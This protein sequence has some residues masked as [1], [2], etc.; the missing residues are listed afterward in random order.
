MTR[1]IGLGLRGHGG[2]GLWGVGWLLVALAGVTGCGREKPVE[3]VMV[4][5]GGTNWTLDQVTAVALAWDKGWLAPERTAQNYDRELSRFWDRTRNSKDPWEELLGYLP[6]V[7]GLPKTGVVRRSGSYEVGELLPGDEELERASLRS[8]MS[9]WREKGWKLVQSEWRTVGFSMK[10]TQPASEVRMTLH[11]EL[12]GAGRRMTVQGELLVEW[13]H[14]GNGSGSGVVPGRVRWLRGEWMAS[15][16]RPRFQEVYRTELEP[17]VS[18]RFAGPVLFA[19]LK[20]AGRDE[21]LLAGANRILGWEVDR[22]WKLRPLL[23]VE[24]L[25]MGSTVMDADRD[26]RLD[27]VSASSAAILTFRGDGEGGFLVPPMVTGAE[28]VVEPMVVAQV[29][30]DRDGL[31][32]IWV[33]QYLSPGEAP[34]P[35]DDADDGYPSSFWRNDGGT[36]TRKTDESGLGWKGRR[37]VLSGVFLDLDGDGWSDLVR[38]CDYA[39]LDVLR[40]GRDGRFEPVT[41][42]WFREGR[43][44]GMS[45]GIADLDGDGRPDLVMTGMTSPTA[46]RMKKLGIEHPDFPGMRRRREEMTYGN[47][48][49][50]NRGNGRWEVPGWGL[51]MADTGWTWGCAWVDPE[52][53]GEPAWY[54]ANGFM[55][56]PSSWDAEG[57]FWC[58][59]AYLE[60]GQSGAWTQFKSGKREEM[61]QELRSLGG[62]HRNM[63][64]AQV[65]GRRRDVAW[66]EGVAASED[67]F[68]VAAWDYDGDGRQ[69]LVVLGQVPGSTDRALLR[70]Y[71]NEGDGGNWLRV[72]VPSH[73]GREP[74]G[75]RVELAMAGG[76]RRHGWLLDQQGFQVQPPPEVHFGLGAMDRVEYVEVS[77]PDGKKRRVANPEINRVLEVRIP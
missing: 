74:W 15:D 5:R 63:L 4:R 50:L 1:G 52:N 65:D 53:S 51:E 41:A 76:G 58:F 33:A 75:G 42:E 14:S 47:R 70:V 49:W 6:S 62:H 55:S 57:E 64:F 24:A 32:D 54:V 30:W 39:G 10:E 27:L 3:P 11:L 36:F 72:R 37:R 8:R 44:F 77:W 16:R 31:M 56:A 45:H 73:G 48:V 29:D 21:V 46:L 71:R 38:V 13:E 67:C 12:A 34:M 43:G 59:D 69:D 17:V 23:G 40:G 19:D 68:N 22:G 2:Y 28:E 26:G 66:L 35:F 20:G 61:V 60:A 18:A 9:G 25:L 7:G